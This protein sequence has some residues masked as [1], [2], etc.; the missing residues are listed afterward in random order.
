MLNEML[1][2]Y[3]LVFPMVKKLNEWEILVSRT[4]DEVGKRPIGS[5]INVRSQHMTGQF[6]KRTKLKNKKW[7]ILSIK[8]G[9]M[10]K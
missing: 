9:G 2:F 4:S 3:L 1:V 6:L 7:E 8:R 10:N 5:I